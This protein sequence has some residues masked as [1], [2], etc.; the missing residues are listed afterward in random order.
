MRIQALAPSKYLV[1]ASVV[2]LT[3]SAY[4]TVSAEDE[5]KKFTD[6]SEAL[7]PLEQIKPNPA[8]LKKY[9]LNQQGPLLR[10][11][12]ELVQQPRAPLQSVISGN[13]EAS[14]SSAAA[15]PG[16]R[17]LKLSV[18]NKTDRPIVL[19][20]NHAIATVGSAR[21]QCAPMSKI[22]QKIP[23]AD[24]PTHKYLKDV[25]ASITAFATVGAAQTLEDKF[26]DMQEVRKHYGFDEA[27]R[28][29][30]EARFGKRI[31]FPGESTTGTL[32]IKTRMPLQDASVV[33]PLSSLGDKNDNASISVSG[34]TVTILAPQSSPSVSLP[35]NE[36][37]PDGS[38]LKGATTD[39]APQPNL[40]RINPSQ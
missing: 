5:I 40:E 24:N 20:G 16:F 36:S 10:P 29:D 9:G 1:L 7:K 30:L 28:E 21:L 22:E 27:R 31:L 12:D 15:E 33:L 4:T 6:P 38:A 8:V 32:F 14:V 18:T 17:T 26:N 19:D 25:R 37:A 3:G 39:G 34:S 11:Q 23:A 2:W 35:Q 13:I